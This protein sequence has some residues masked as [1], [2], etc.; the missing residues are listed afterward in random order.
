MKEEVLDEVVC[1]SLRESWASESE[2]MVGEEHGPGAF[3]VG[4]YVGVVEVKALGGG[5]REAGTERIWRRVRCGER[6]EET[7]R[8]GIEE[9]L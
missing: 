4:S 7:M 6:S 3:L 2:V 8:Y 9:T 5:A 1:I